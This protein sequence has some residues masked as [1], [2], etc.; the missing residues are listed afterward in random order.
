MFLTCRIAH[1]IPLHTFSWSSWES[2]GRGH[3][4]SLPEAPPL[5]RSWYIHR[6][7]TWMTVLEMLSH[8]FPKDFSILAKE[9]RGLHEMFLHP[10]SQNGTTLQQLLR[11][12]LV[13]TP[14]LSSHLDL[15][16]TDFP[17]SS[18]PFTPSVC[19]HA[20]LLQLVLSLCDPMNCSHQSSLSMEFLRQE[21]WNG[22]S[23]P[24]PCDLPY[25]GLKF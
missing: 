14:E 20:Q 10:E 22:L 18:K 8:S 24:P 25:R 3:Q 17:Q 23:C 13:Q 16:H 2:Q 1:T 5:E 9:T 4:V 21:Y 7:E 15:N 12:S 6:G 11:P 19:V